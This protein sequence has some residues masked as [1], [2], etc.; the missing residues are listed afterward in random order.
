M[1]LSNLHW[2]RN[3]KRSASTQGNARYPDTRMGVEQVLMMRLPVQ[4]IIRKH[5]QI[6]RIK[7][8]Q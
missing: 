7:S 4:K 2:V 1:A 8:L 5:G 6:T 3:V